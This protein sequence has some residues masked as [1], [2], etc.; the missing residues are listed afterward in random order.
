MGEMQGGDPSRLDG[1][2]QTAEF[3][4][5]LE[6]AGALRREFGVGIDAHPGGEGVEAG[7]VNRAFRAMAG[8][9]LGG[10][11]TPGDDLTSLTTWALRQAALRRLVEHGVD[12]KDAAGLIDREP[13]LEDR[14]LAYLA[15]ASVSVVEDLI[16]DRAE[17]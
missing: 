12:A 17:E 1:Y 3:H 4:L 6:I 7:V 8:V 14:W 9:I 5:I 15:L 16:G 10:I 13:G 2:E 11:V